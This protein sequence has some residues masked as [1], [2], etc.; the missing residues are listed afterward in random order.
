MRIV[1]LLAIAF[2]GCRSE[3][4][5]PPPPAPSASVT[6]AVSASAA[7]IASSAPPDAATTV[8]QLP[9]AGGIP[10]T[11][12]K[13]MEAW[14]RAR[15]KAAANGA[16]LVRVPLVRRTDGWGC[17][18]PEHYLGTSA[19]NGTDSMTWIT[20]VFAPTAP[21]LLPDRVVLAEGYFTG[22]RETFK[23]DST[24]EYD[25]VTV[26]ELQVLRHRP[27]SGASD[28]DRPAVE[29]SA[30]V[31]LPG[32]DAH[33]ETPAP[34]D[35]N[36]FLLIATSIP[37]SDKAAESAERERA[38]LAAKGFTAV[39]VLDTRRVPGLFCCHLV[40]V[41]S[42]HPTEAVAKEAAAA[43]G[44]KGVKVLVRRGW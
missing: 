4:A 11:D 33:Q 19:L 43:A 26:H 17:I 35:G 29:L 8:V 13:A 1:L 25:K 41:A 44:R 24:E 12:G 6:A 3:K 39:E 22:K 38:K 21:P 31:L 20:P 34:E 28:E 42:R 23:A 27:L 40:V 10:V 7:P 32:K 9:D 15:E 16:E 37:L 30:A 5:S 36:R 14:V 18:C 2:A